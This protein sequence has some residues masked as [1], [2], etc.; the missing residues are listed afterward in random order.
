MFLDAINPDDQNPDR[1]QDVKVEAHPLSREE[2]EKAL[3]TFE[4]Q[5]GVPSDRMSEAFSRSP[6]REDPDFLEWSHLY[7]TWQV[8]PER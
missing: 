8:W 6:L 7:A 2:I 4:E 3:H 5:Y 1:R